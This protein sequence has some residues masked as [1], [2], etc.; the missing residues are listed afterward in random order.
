M[1]ARE[2][3][4]VAGIGVDDI[5]TFDL[6]SCFPFPV[7][8][9]CEA[10]G[11]AGDD[12]R[13]LTLTGGLP[14]F[15]GPGNSYS[16]HGIAATVN[17]M[18]DRP[19]QFGLVGANGGIMSK[20]SVG[21]YSTTPVDWRPDRSAE[22][23]EQIGALPKVEVTKVPDGAGTIETYSVRYDWPIRTGIIVGHVHDDGYICEGA[24][25]FDT[26]ENH[27]PRT[28]PDRP[29]WQVESLEPLTISPSILVSEDKG[30]CGL[31]GFIRQGAWQ[32]AELSAEVSN[33]RASLASTSCI[34]LHR[35]DCVTWTSCR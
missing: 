26:P 19:R 20:C 7:F 4:R 10:L 11:I 25:L 8:I 16:L 12:P 23:Q 28:S 15:G 21:I 9:I 1:A 35:T 6:Y 22:L 24:V 18:R 3:L 14:Y 34:R 5:A 30:G 31:H 13:G 29:L 32:P 33:Q 2:A 27:P 17:Q